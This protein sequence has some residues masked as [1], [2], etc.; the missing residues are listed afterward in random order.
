MFN[1]LKNRT[2]P[3]GHPVLVGD[4]IWASA[5]YRWNLIFLAFISLVVTIAVWLRWSGLDSQSLWM[6]EGY[7]LWISRFSPR[8]IW[9][10]LEIDTS[11]P[12]YYILLHYWSRCF[13]T[14]EL[15]LRGLSALFETLSVPLFYAL[16]RKILADKVSIAMAMLLNA[17]SFFHIWYARETRCYA[18][19]VFLSLGSVYFLLLCLEKRSARR[20]CALVLF[21]AASLY[22]HNIAL[23][24]LPGVAIMWLIYPSEKT[25]RA[26]VREGLLVFSAT[27][28]L[29]IPWLPTLHGQL[30]RVRLGF[31]VARP[32]LRDLLDSL[33]VLSGFDAHTFQNVVRAR[34]HVLRLFGFWT[35][36]PLVLL[37]FGLC[38][39]GGF[40]GVR[41]ADRRKVAALLVYSMTPVLLVFADSSISSS[42][43]ITRLFLGSCALLPMVLFAPIA[44]Q[45]G[46]SKKLFYV[47]G[48]V[49]LV[50]GSVSAV[51]YL[52]RERKEDWRGVTEYIG[53]IPEKQRLT[54][55]IPDI[56]QPVV[57]YYA[58]GLSKSSPPMEMTGLLTRFDPPD[59][60]LQRRIVELSDNQQTDV[61]ALLSH[62]TA[63]G[64]YKEIDVALEPQASLLV[65]PMLEYLAARCSSVEVVAFHWLEV[66]R[67]SIRLTKVD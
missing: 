23:F 5:Q 55:I 19:L 9:R 36:A 50:G 59:A 31:W 12:L 28:F 18:L 42:I 40:R 17:V 52:R 8:A 39:I 20:L 38:V 49:I 54:V 61:L 32:R 27:L 44:F 51:G 13:G 25:I 10:L 30:Q 21:L 22:T 67:C 41:P 53:K 35:W 6:D 63:S 47:L 48:F 15:S 1:R 4:S 57:Q 24:Y 56:C 29:Y 26:R 46:K 34:F 3:T 7:S 60:G 66:R 33:C 37:V 11:A 2:N 65:K 43:Y 16:G 58:A 14:S 45:V 62:E 64:R